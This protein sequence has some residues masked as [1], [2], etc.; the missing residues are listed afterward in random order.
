MTAGI[1]VCW[2]FYIGCGQSCMATE[3]LCAVLSLSLFW[4]YRDGVRLLNRNSLSNTIRKLFFSCDIDFS[5][6]WWKRERQNFWDTRY[7]KASCEKRWE[8]RT[9]F[10][11]YVI[12]CEQFLGWIGWQYIEFASPSSLGFLNHIPSQIICLGINQ[13]LYWDEIQPATNR[14]GPI[15]FNHFYFGGIS[16]RC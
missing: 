8:W 5:I 11:D 10:D 16:F 15:N 1:L 12:I 3:I 13:T 2:R 4:E 14:S 9:R 6:Y 7:H